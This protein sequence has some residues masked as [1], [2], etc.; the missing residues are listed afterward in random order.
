ML[1]AG[2]RQRLIGVLGR[3]ASDHDGERAAAA[4]MAPPVPAAPEQAA[5]LDAIV[6]KVGLG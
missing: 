6:R 2:D 5:T 4:L 1:T 3:L